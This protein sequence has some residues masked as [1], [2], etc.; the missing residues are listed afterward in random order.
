MLEMKTNY[1]YN[2][3]TMKTHQLLSVL[4]PGEVSEALGITVQAIYQW[5]EEV[6]RLRQYEIRDFL[7]LH[8]PEKLQELD[9]IVASPATVEKAGA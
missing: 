8:R 4:T 1:A 5:P 3:Q 6:P 7:C 9:L 2:E